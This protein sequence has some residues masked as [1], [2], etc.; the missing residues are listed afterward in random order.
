MNRFGKVAS[1]WLSGLLAC[2]ALLVATSDPLAADEAE[3]SESLAAQRQLIADLGDTSFSVREAAARQLAAQG[4]DAKPAL[5]EALEHVDL[6]IRMRAHQILV[7]SLHIDFERRLSDFIADADGERKHQLP[8]WDRFRE[9]IGSDRPSRKLFV[10]MVRLE[11]GL[12]EALDEGGPE[13][14]ALFNKRVQELQSRGFNSFYSGDKVQ[15]ATLA[16]MLFVGCEAEGASQTSSSLLFSLLNQSTMQQVINEGQHARLMKRLL[17]RWIVQRTNSSQ[18]YYS[19]LLA[20][21]YNLKETGLKLGRQYLDQNSPSTTVL[22]YA[23]IAVGRFGDKSDV[24]RLEKHL[25]NQ[26]VCHTW[27]NRQ[28]KKD[29]LIRIQIR[30][31]MLV[32]LLHVSDQNPRQYGFNLLQPNPTTMYHI[33]TF[34]FVDDT[35]RAAAFD[36]YSKSRKTG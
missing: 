7:R 22:Q 9:S 3:S 32:M 5:L 13:L 28:L 35:E 27:S 33:Y 1:G 24:E 31:I 16:A 10:E 2:L 30:D 6:E 11:P 18:A 34:G 20:L 29:G 36:K 14:T 15:P 4:L 12:L 23:A 21:S 19:L 8:A 26:T 17:D 25:A